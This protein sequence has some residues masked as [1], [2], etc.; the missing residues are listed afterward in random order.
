MPDEVKKEEKK[1]LGL[2]LNNFSVAILGSI[3]TMT[4][5]CFIWWLNYRSPSLV[6]KPSDVII[7]KG[8]NNKVGILIIYIENQGSDKAESVNCIVS[9][10]GG[11]I[12]EVKT[13]PSYFDTNVTI[14]NSNSEARIILKMLN[15]G[16]TCSVSLLL[17]DIDNIKNQPT[18]TVR[19]AGVNGT[20]WSSQER[21]DLI[22]IAFNMAIV[23]VIGY[24][25]IIVWYVYRNYKLGIAITELRKSQSAAMPATVA[26]EPM[27]SP[28]LD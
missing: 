17:A 5:A 23:L 9:F 7:F 21:K 26:I 14:N 28:L 27:E 2:S 1:V 11:T 3:L 4:V 18:I 13:M 12:N 25:L 22:S 19:G 20:V 16:E 8:D 10:N 15:S 24:S 6:V